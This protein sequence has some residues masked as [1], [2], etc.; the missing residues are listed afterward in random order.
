ML[1]NPFRPGFGSWP[2]S[3]VGREHVELL[4]GEGLSNGPGSRYH[5]SLVTG[6]RGLGKTVLLAAFR[7]IAE[8]RG[9]RTIAVDA[10]DGMIRRIVRDL[11][12]LQDELAETGRWKL[13]KAQLGASA[14]VARGH[15]DFTRTDA[16]STFADD[17]ATALKPLLEQVTAH[18][19]ERGGAGLLLTVDEMHAAKPAELE[20]LG[21]DL[22][23]VQEVAFAGAALPSIVD[24]IFGERGA[25]FFSRIA[26]FELEPLTTAESMEAL[27]PP[28][29]EAAIAYERAQMTR[30]A[31]RT[32]GYPYL[33]QLLGYEI[34]HRLEP[35]SSIDEPLIDEAHEAAHQQSILDV[36]QP[37]WRQLSP[38]SKRVLHIVAEDS[39]GQATVREIRERLDKSSS[40]V[41]VY[42]SRLIT[43]GILR[44]AG[45]GVVE[46]T[47]G[48]RA[49]QW[50]REQIEDD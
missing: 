37:T 35:D 12:L 22:Q 33:V 47:G 28:F 42:R 20:R 30:A 45:R 43:S 6:A 21:N 40:W 31:D 14:G 29:D 26:R 16:S 38:S 39:H 9:Y 25:T 10:N 18:V 24:Q 34:W 3:F 36:L 50:I 48:E 4:F 41:S 15:V 8:A 5:N 46:L 2:P 44:S 11:L 13:S 27:C 7:D 32:L 19:V 1:N 23:H 49:A 17:P